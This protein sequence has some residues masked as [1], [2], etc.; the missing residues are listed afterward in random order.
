MDGQAAALALQD[1]AETVAQQLG[2]L[3]NPR[4]LLILC[5]LAGGEKSV[6]ALQQAAGLSQSALSQH[7][8]KMREAGMV[9]TRREAQ[10]IHYRINDPDLERLIGALYEIYCKDLD[11]PETGG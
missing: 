9:A 8:A 4:R 11:P 7:L 10:T 5:E 3:A 2:M 1:R 6:G